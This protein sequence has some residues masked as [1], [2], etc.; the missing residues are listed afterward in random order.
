MRIVKKSYF[1]YLPVSLFGSI[2]GLSGFSIGLNSAVDLYN[3]SPLFGS[4]MTI[5]TLICFTALIIAYS[6][7]IFTSRQSFID[8]FQNPVTKSF[9]GTIGISFL[10]IPLLFNDTFLPLGFFFWIIGVVFMLVFAWYMVNFWVQNT[11][12][13]AHITPAWI[14]PVVGTL[15]IPLASHLFGIDSYFLNIFALSVGLFF[16]LPIITLILSRVIFFQKLPEKLMPTLMILVAPFS[17][18]F[19]AYINS[20]GSLDYFA[21]ALYSLGF[22]IFLT[23]IPQLFNIAQ[24]CPFRVTWWAISFPLAALLNA[25]L[26]MAQMLDNTLF[27]YLGAVMLTTFSGI[28]IWLIGTTLKAIFTKKLQTIS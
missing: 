8:E 7:K 20:V 25:T 14:V 26:K 1:S 18:G 24:C 28:F 23:L 19:L 22:F 16:T 4:V 3:I 11:H 27:Y 10:L 13:Q 21:M 17:V 6:I 2:M 5:F 12:E 15:D 9:F